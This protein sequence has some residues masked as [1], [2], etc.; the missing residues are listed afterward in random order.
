MVVYDIFLGNTLLGVVSILSSGG[1]A[2]GMGLAW[3]AIFII[4]GLMIASSVCAFVGLVWAL[5]STDASGWHKFL[6]GAAWLL[7]WTPFF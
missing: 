3:Q 2:T 1:A 5:L 7:S 6:A 4:F